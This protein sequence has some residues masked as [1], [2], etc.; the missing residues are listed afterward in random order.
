MISNSK[1]P[2]IKYKFT[3]QSS[4]QQFMSRQNNQIHY[5]YKLPEE[6]IN[7]YQTVI[8]SENDDVDM[9]NKRNLFRNSKNN[10]IPTLYIQKT[11]MI[12]N[13]TQKK[14][15]RNLLWYNKLYI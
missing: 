11:I 12:L 7:K 5:F 1:V 4:Q 3:N 6:N 2:Y 10:R 15:N 14:L 8:L 13:K 9:S